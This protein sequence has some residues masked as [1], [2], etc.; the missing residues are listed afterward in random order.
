MLTDL[1][2]C[3][4]GSPACAPQIIETSE[5]NSL[6]TS[7]NSMYRLQKEIGNTKLENSSS[8]VTIQSKTYQALPL[9]NAYI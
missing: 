3:C 8:G 5:K 6:L 1:A 9:V 4:A 2:L 7:K